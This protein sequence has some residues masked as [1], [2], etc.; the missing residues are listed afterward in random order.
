MAKDPKLALAG[1]CKDSNDEQGL[2]DFHQ[3]YFDRH[4]IYNDEK[5]QLYQAMG[6]RKLGV[7]DLVKATVV[8]PLRWHKK[9]ITSS[10][11][12]H[13]SDAWMIGGV[14]VFDQTG[15]LVYAME[16]SVVEE[17]PIDRLERAIQGARNRN[18]AAATATASEN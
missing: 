11:T 16:E 17:F 6:G 12:R 14:L 1:I 9:G 18:A 8:A 4:A 2:L 15:N 3:S 7:W 10:P 5:W 13:Q